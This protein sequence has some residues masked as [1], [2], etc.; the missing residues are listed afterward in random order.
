MTFTHHLSLMH[1]WVPTSV[2]VITALVLVAAIGR[3]T[4][5]WSLIWLPVAAVV[6]GIL[7]A[8]T[9]WYIESEGLAGN[10]APRS[11]WVWIGLTGV[12]VVVLIAGWRGSR[13]WRRGTAALAVPMT[14]LCTALAVNL[15][16]GYFPWVQT[17]WNQFTAGPLPDQ[18]DQVTVTAM[19]R[20]GAIP[21]KGTVVP[22]EIPNTASGFRHRGE[23][24][25]LPPAWFA[26]NPPPQLPTVMMIGGEFNTPADWMRAGNVIKTMDDFAA[27]HRGYAPLLVFVDPGGTFNNDTECVNGKRGNS[28]D[29]LTKDV[30]PYMNSH[31]GSKPVAGGWG[32]VGWSMGGTCAVDLA[33]MHPELF[34]AFV[35]I[36]GDIGPNSGTKAQTIDRLFGGNAAAWDAFDPSTVITRHGQ[37]EQTAGWF[38][39]NDASST[40]RPAAR[41]SD[42][43]KAANALCGLGSTHGIDCAVIT[44]PGTHDWPFAAHAF[45]AA[46]PWLAGALGTPQ[47]PTVGLPQSPTS[48]SYIQTA[49]K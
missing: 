47:V 21:A 12:A 44:Q 19:Q 13:W 37:Y 8:G 9:H 6:G 10:P 25:Y 1:G 23:Y 14:L 41:G 4:R 43:A 32:V 11:L 38:G 2:Q 24:V 16:V 28:A 35:D 29:H 31:Y 39:V 27:A 48:A 34:S 18:T 42:Q 49:A 36:A 30:V 26:A 33:V 20:Q 46:L 22:V 17:A 15:W 45:S 40:A 3:H 7:V 5:R